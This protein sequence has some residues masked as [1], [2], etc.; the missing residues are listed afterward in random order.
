MKKVRI[1]VLVSGRGSNL[2]AVIDNIELGLLAAEI[3]VVI[4]DQADA[5]SLERAKNH[6]IPAVH[7]SAKGYKGKRDAYDALLVQELQKRGVELVCLA[8]FMRIIT[9]VLIAAFPHRILN[10]HPSLLPAFPGL[11]VQ[12]KALEHGVKFSG[13]TV[14]FVDEGM[15]TG[16]IIIQAVVPIL[17]NDTE[18]SLSTRILQQEH[19]IY[20]RAIQLFAEGR[21]KVESNRVSVIGGLTESNAFLINP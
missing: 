7:I 14:H 15:D 13:C 4:S 1:G 21:L 10:I 12:K 17:D 2:Q 19:K 5:Y 20:S 18:E 6:N 9:P 3:A 11:H 16:P 8:G